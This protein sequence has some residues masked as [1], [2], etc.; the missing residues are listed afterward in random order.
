LGD[1]DAN[2]VDLK[3]RDPGLADCFLKLTGRPLYD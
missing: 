3:V 2:L 1:L